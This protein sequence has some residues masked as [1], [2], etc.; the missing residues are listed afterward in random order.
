M[1]L[2]WDK[3][4]H[5]NSGG[6]SFLEFRCSMKDF[7]SCYEQL[8]IYRL[9]IYNTSHNTNY[10]GLISHPFTTVNIYHSDQEILYDSSTFDT[11]L[12]YSSFV[13]YI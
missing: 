7:S 13:S 3:F 1:L 9:A 12:R 6:K 4:I 10:T 8:A 2:I 11:S 5:T